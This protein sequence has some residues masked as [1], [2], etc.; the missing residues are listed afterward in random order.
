MSSKS[1][2]DRGLAIVMEAGNP[3]ERS[4]MLVATQVAHTLNKHYPDH[5]WHVLVQGGGILL[6]HHAISAVADSFLKRQGFGFLMPP[7]KLGTPKEIVRSAISAG[8][9]MLEL[10]GLPRGRAPIPDPDILA[11]SGLVK[12][13][14]DWRKGQQR[15]FA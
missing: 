11:A 7:E 4:L 3:E 5:L 14:R 1:R 9:H 12:I 15:R 6:R 2:N 8:G 13:P 10:F